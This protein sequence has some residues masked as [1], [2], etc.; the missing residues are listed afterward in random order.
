MPVVMLSILFYYFVFISM[1]RHWIFTGQIL[2]IWTQITLPVE[3]W[4][5]LAEALA[6]Q[7]PVRS[8]C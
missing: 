4:L 7:F 5:V 3:W 6:V 1:A 8:G 2:Y